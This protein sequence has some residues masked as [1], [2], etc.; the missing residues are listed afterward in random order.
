M[1]GE[2]VFVDTN[3]L[4][5]ATYDGSPMHSGALALLRAAHEG[6]ARL[7]LSRQVL[8]EFLATTTRS[9]ADAPALLPT[10]AAIEDVRRF[11]RDFHVVE[12]GP[13]VSTQLLRLLERY[14]TAGRQ[15][16]DANIVATMLA[17]GV[18]RLLTYNAADFRRYAG[19]IV[20]EPAP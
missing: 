4:V 11:S 8:R 13:Q 14:P 7:C 16:H 1:A 20:I 2:L 15:V 6:G 5:Y 18:R 9:A 12:D 17:H 19:E 10:T 3:V